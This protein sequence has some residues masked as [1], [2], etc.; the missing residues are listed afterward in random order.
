MARWHHSCESWMQW[1]YAGLLLMLWSLALPAHADWEAGAS[2]VEQTIPVSGSPLSLALAKDVRLLAVGRDLSPGLVLVDPDT[3]AELASLSLP[4]KPVALA[5]TG[6]GSRA[7]AIL[8]GTT[9]V[10]VVDIAAS[11][12]GVAHIK[13]QWPVG[14]QPVGLLLDAGRNRVYVADRQSRLVVLDASTGQV[15]G[16]LPVLGK[17]LRMALAQGGGRLLI[18]TQSGDLLTVDPTNLSVTNQIN[19]GSEI[20]GL[21]WWDT[22]SLAI[23]IPRNQDKWLLVN[24]YSTTLDTAKG[25]EGRLEGMAVDAQADN[26]YVTTSEDL[27]I[28]RLNLTQRVNEGRHRL[29]D[30]P[31]DIA[32]DPVARMLY[33]ALPL[34]GKLLR[35]DPL[36]ANLVPPL[37]MRFRYRDVAVHQAKEQAFA[38]T[39]R[40][41]GL[42]TRWRLSD[43]FRTVLPLNK[44][45]TRK[46]AIDSASN[47]A[48]IGVTAPGHEI[49][50][51]DLA[52][53]SPVLLKDVVNV[54]AEVFA[55]AA[56]PVGK[57]S[58]VLVNDSQGIRIISHATRQ[59]IA[60]LATSEVF[61]SI[62][63]HA[64][65]G[66][67]YLLSD[68]RRL[69]VLDLASLQFVQ[70]LTL[71]FEPGSIALDEALNL[72]AI[73][74][75]R[76]N[77][78][79]ILDL[80]T[81]AFTRA[82]DL[83]RHPGH[84]AVH[85]DFHTVV[86]AS[87]ESDALSLV[88][89]VDPAVE[90]QQ[91]TAVERPF[92]VAVAN[93]LNQA[94]V[95]SGEKDDLFFVS[96]PTPKPAL[97]A[98]LPAQ[99]ASGS[100]ALVLK[101]QGYRFSPSSLVHWNGA[102]LTT[103]YKDAQNL[104]ADV[105]A[106]LLQNAGSVAVSVRTPPPGAGDSH[107]LNFEITAPAPVLDAISP[108][109][110]LANGSPQTINL[111]GSRFLSS[112]QVQIGGQAVPTQY[113][114]G[115]ALAATVPG[116]LLESPTVLS[117]A[118]YTPLGGLSG[119]LPL[120]VK[121]DEQKLTL[122][123]VTPNSGETGTQVVLS[124]TGFDPDPA[125]N[126]V[127]FAGDAIA[128]VTQASATQITVVVP[129]NAQTGPVT[130]SN[131]RGSV[132]GPSFTVTR[133]N[134]FSLVATPGSLTLLQNSAAAVSVQLS[135]STINPFTGLAALSASGL[136][137]GVTASFE[138]P[139]LAANQPGVLR[140]TAAATASN[141]T[142]PVTLTATGTVAGA[143]QSRT[144][145][146]NLTVQASAGVT[147]VK[148]RFVT[149]SGAGIPGVL[150]SHENIT[151]SSDSAGNFL[152]TGLPSGLL[153]LRI[154]ATPAHP[155]YPIWPA[156]VEIAASQ[157]SQLPDWTITP[158]PP[159]EQ[160]TPLAQNSATPQVITD[161]RYPGVAVTIPAG[162]S[163]IGWDGVP[164]SRIAVEKI[165]MDKTGV[166]TPPVPMK[167]VYQLFFGTPMGG[168]PSE[169]IP[170]TL[171]NVAG[172]D[173]G[174]K[175]EIWYFDGSPMGGAGEWKRAGSATVSQ[176]GSTVTT[177]PGQGVPRFC[178]KC[179][180][181][182]QSCPP[183]NTGKKTS[184]GGQCEATT[185]A[186]P[187]DL[188]SGYAMSNLGGMSCG[189]YAPMEM[190]LSYH[191]VDTFQGRAGLQGSVGNGWVLDF[192]VVLGDNPVLP[193]FKQLIVPPNNRVTFLPESDGTFVNKTDPR[194]SGAVLRLTDVTARR[195]ELKFKDGRVWRFT[196]HSVAGEGVF[197][198]EIEDVP[199][200][201]VQVSR[202]SDHKITGIGTAQRQFAFTY[203]ASN[204]VEKISDPLGRE[205][206]FTYNAASRI[207]TMTDPEGGVTRFTYVDDNEFPAN[208]V[209]A[210]G[211][212]DGLRIKTIQ[213]PGSL[214]PTENSY[215]TSRRVLRQTSY[216][217]EHS[218]SYQVTGACVVNVAKPGERC[219]VGCPDVDSWENF[220]TGWRFY[221][222][223]VIATTVTD[224][225]GNVEHRRYSAGGYINEVQDYAGPSRSYVRDGQNQVTRSTDVLGRTTAYVRDAKG[226]VTRETDALGRIA[227]IEYDVKWNKPSK[228]TRYLADGTPVAS[229]VKYHAS[230]GKPIAFTN[231]EGNTVTLTYTPEGQV[232][233][234]TD[235]LGNVTRLHYNNAGDLID[236]VDPMGH[237]QQF[238][239][240]LAGRLAKITD[241]NGFDWRTTLNGLDQ[242][243]ASID[244]QG[245]TTQL[246]YTPEHLLASVTDALGHAVESYGHDARGR[247]TQVTDPKGGT[248]TYEYDSIGNLVR[249]TDRK[250]QQ[251]TFAYDPSN[252][253]IEAS[254]PGSTLRY[255]YDAVGR[256]VALEE[257]GGA[258]PSAFDYA[259]DQGD[260]LVRETIHQLGQ[261]HVI[262]YKY[263]NLDRRVERQVD[264]VDTTT[265]AYDK[266]GRVTRIQFNAEPPVTYA[267]DAASRLTVKTLSNGVRMEYLYDAASRLTKITYRKPDGSEID[268][269]AYG[270]DPKG[271]RVSRTMGFPS[272]DETPM[273]ATYDE[274]NRMVTFTLTATGETF[275][276]AYDAN[277]S[278]VSKT[279]R[280][281]GT[282]T[283]YSWD[284]RDRLAAISG[285]GVTASFAYDA[286]GRRISKTVNGQTVQFTYDG[287]EIIGELS[288]GAINVRLLY[289]LNL[290]ELLARIVSAGPQNYLTDALGSA[291][292]LL[293]NDLSVVTGY[294]YSSFGEVQT[295]GD[296]HGNQYSFTG[297]ESDVT[298]VNYYRSR[299]YDPALKRFI[300]ADM[301]GMDGGINL[302]AYVNGNPINFVDPFGKFPWA[303]IGGATAVCGL[304]STLYV[305]GNEALYTWNRVV[306]NCTHLT[307]KSLERCEDNAESEAWANF[308]SCGLKSAD[309]NDYIPIEV[310]KRNPKIPARPEKK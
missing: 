16:T 258:S 292:L 39:E 158:P 93:R 112:S 120:E 291:M 54:G 119:A 257:T 125:K 51:V 152:L 20:S 296:D 94:L 275:D 231:P 233:S 294:A 106:T 153:T 64:Q 144:A 104:E 277:G 159:D 132:A 26:A 148:G 171:P 245:G 247:V 116:A 108:P 102:P 223:Q 88:D 18:G 172:L 43:R 251:F 87:K 69:S 96:L 82:V 91:L 204:L 198:T 267:W 195:W 58:L 184:G 101:A 103:R 154:N 270:Y 114:G 17:P 118:V 65:G 241:P 308:S 210:A 274:A 90:T 136:T 66:R 176:D 140:L 38:V 248:K 234:V 269:I 256:L 67:A 61:R 143:K 41:N 207:E 52:P 62:A 295:T 235:P 216:L 31:G 22:D 208:P 139:N 59:Q 193:N 238:E 137:S 44:A 300:S 127:K 40:L 246:A 4:T 168:I 49:R 3:G 188:Y 128:A 261:T 178:G 218:F 279:S 236:M 117:V 150:V 13:S 80:N 289:G 2:T 215:G 297:R 182:G 81:M 260:R 200:N 214:V 36:Q 219:T 305:C 268:S 203:G 310:P 282:V 55:L 35:L 187:V 50:F 189:G 124:G 79:R 155:L 179:G 161:A 303:I 60:S 209:C 146:V 309:P 156:M 239:N 37:A 183:L 177:D 163:I 197:L 1:L 165:D 78:L 285:P 244:P 220:E 298:K 170:V 141:G 30:T 100:P 99:A 53:A 287:S 217:G 299:Y 109:F 33:V 25:L 9:A 263:D 24:P 242:P 105:P 27:S 206:R 133:A 199:G 273:A 149:P 86:V 230:L 48:V 186:N 134:D 164:K 84:L 281:N 162:A 21:V 304:F 252:R 5:L 121:S 73:T 272:R 47:L 23:A 75:P 57:R 7:L 123:A 262:Q 266:A 130:V 224:P 173:P 70:S 227:D 135:T 221:G 157:V 181:V 307:G 98:L 19:L 293:N 276:L 288:D 229:V 232:A 196:D 265:Y 228:V 111:T 10:T 74:S 14:G 202:R 131:A 290:D 190:G 68:Q 45:A 264:G 280:V 89:L 147:G 34:E 225:N 8:Q 278:L 83:P 28:N 92:S 160:F 211:G 167:E 71:D 259:Y 192:D 205:M 301:A 249:H 255:A 213:Y 194:F 63:I 12:G 145:V 283:T 284:V 129:A 142:Y 250:G 72:A 6:D 15:V 32:F 212:S 77:V 42:L 122:T 151:T 166:P 46:I 138:P 126:V 240:D 306:D 95:L 253:L 76:E 180:L 222:G 302:Y 226:N 107:N 115:T 237:T 254:L 169:P 174:A 113:I 286:M 175:S 85:P 110:L 185:K 201:L 271:Q 97:T 191:P 11:S 29:N 56:D 243:T